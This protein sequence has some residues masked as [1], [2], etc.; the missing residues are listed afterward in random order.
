VFAQYRNNPYL[1]E[2]TGSAAF[3]DGSADWS[4]IDDATF[5]DLSADLDGD[6]DV[7]KADVD[8][9]VIGILE[10]QYGDANLDGVV[11]VGDLG[12]LA[13][14]WGTTE[15]AGWCNAD[16]T[17]DGSVDVGDLGVLA[18]QWGFGGSKSVPEPTT[19]VLLGLGGLAAITRRRK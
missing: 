4:D 2:V 9:L 18:G 19:M 6:L 3:A 16:F 5:F 8:E 15:G 12:I 1:L 7:D 11:D 17:G 14:A 13:G 10:T